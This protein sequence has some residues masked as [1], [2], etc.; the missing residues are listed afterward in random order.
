M[1]QC[2]TCDDECKSTLYFYSNYFSPLKQFKVLEISEI[3]C[4]RNFQSLHYMFDVLSKDCKQLLLTCLI[5]AIKAK[6]FPL[7]VKWA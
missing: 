3:T 1:K 7:C 2:E 5:D 6:V 4:L